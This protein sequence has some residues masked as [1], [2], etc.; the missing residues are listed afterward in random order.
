VEHDDEGERQERGGPKF[1]KVLRPPF[2]RTK[3]VPA[4]VNRDLA[5]KPMPKD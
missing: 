5:D 4:S 1:R 3:T 2:S